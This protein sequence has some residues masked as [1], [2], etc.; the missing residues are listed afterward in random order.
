MLPLV[1]S[2]KVGKK[3]YGI[4]RKVLNGV[5]IPVLSHNEQKRIVELYKALTR[6]VDEAGKQLAEANAELTTLIPALL[7]EAFRGGL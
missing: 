6:R 7:A 2:G 1:G 3:V 4:T 5:D